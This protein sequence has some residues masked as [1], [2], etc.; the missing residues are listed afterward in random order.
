MKNMICMMLALILLAGVCAPAA[1]A[2]CL[3]RCWDYER[4]WERMGNACVVRAD[5][6]RYADKDGNGI[7]D[8]CGYS[9]CVAQSIVCA[10]EN[11]GCWQSGDNGGHHGGHH[12]GKHHG[13]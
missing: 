3:E 4:R 11:R 12:G 8:G 13:N 1:E 6:T 5:C 2:A 7:C 9:D 10:S